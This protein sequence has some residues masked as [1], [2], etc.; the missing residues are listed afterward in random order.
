M[1]GASKASSMLTEKQ[2]KALR[3]AGWKIGTVK[4]LLGLT[5]KEMMTI[6]LMVKAAI[7]KRK[8]GNG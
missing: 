1:A 2:K 6:D 7:R 5:D 3:K 4:E 8:R